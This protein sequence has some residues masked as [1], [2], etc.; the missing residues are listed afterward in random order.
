MKRRPT[1]ILVAAAIRDAAGAN[2]RPGAVAI[3]DG[4][5]VAA[6][7]AEAVLN[8]PALDP[9]AVRGLPG[10]MLLPGL[11]NAHAHLELTAIGP[12]PYEPQRGFIGWLRD[13]IASAAKLDRV[14]SAVA[15][16]QATLDAG[17]C[18][19]GNIASSQ[20][21][22]AAVEEAGLEGS[23]YLEMFGLGEPF[24]QASLDTMI[25]TRHM[26]LQ[27][28]APYS[29]GPRLYMETAHCGLANCTH[30]AETLEE[31]QFVR[32]ATGPFRELLE[33][34]GRWRDEFAAHYTGHRSS[35]QWMK[36]YLEQSAVPWLLA[37]CNYVSD[38][39]M[40]LLR[41][42]GSSV[43]YCPVASHYFGHTGHRYREMLDAGINVCL[44]T[45]SIIC[46]PP[47]E[48]QPLG[49]LPQMRFL[50]QRDHTDPDL[51]L[52]MATVNGAKA[53]GLATDY[54][55]LLPGAPAHLLAV[56]VSAQ[57]DT[58]PLRQVLRESGNVEVLHV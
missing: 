11:V 27:P 46:Q 5:I 13:V 41:D 3:R 33:S 6:G 38:D 20:S 58:D 43:A 10:M 34:L 26:E 16:A 47:N 48:E 12:R 31:H 35:V 42:A 29:A 30:L 55:T 49:I 44:G 57:D 9:A 15:G 2:A 36:P 24:D 54:A 51:L 1:R 23:N 28:H 25:Q 21:V 19:V 39:D 52:K 40:K 50:H 45:D 22:I 32:D 53:L 4:R 14:A 56:P 8:D 7:E 17:V 37:H 18:A